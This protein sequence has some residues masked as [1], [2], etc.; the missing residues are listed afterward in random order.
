MF[1]DGAIDFGR[2]GSAVSD[3]GFDGPLEV[4]L[5]DEQGHSQIAT[6]QV[7]SREHTCYLDSSWE[8]SFLR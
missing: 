7:D 3:I 4:E 1:G 2:I 8:P 5:S 6:L